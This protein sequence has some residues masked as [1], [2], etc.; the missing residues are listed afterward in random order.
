MIGMVRGWVPT[1][2]FVPT[3]S[4]ATQTYR[5][6]T[7]TSF[8]TE[9]L[10]AL[11]PPS[12]QGIHYSNLRTR[13]CATK[14]NC[15]HATL[16]DFAPNDAQNT[17]HHYPPH[18]HATCAGVQSSYQHPRPTS[19]LHAHRVRQ[20]MPSRLR[21]LAGC[22]RR[23]RRALPSSSG[24]SGNPIPSPHSRLGTYCPMAR[25]LLHTVRGI[26]AAQESWISVCDQ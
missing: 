13:R 14:S 8:H 21:I 25:S 12:T 24:T 3:P 17:P 4:H 10:S 22:C 18:C 23:I 19:H 2:L 7:A 20:H 1:L 11:P 16:H 9:L 5:T 26:V 15:S 6:V